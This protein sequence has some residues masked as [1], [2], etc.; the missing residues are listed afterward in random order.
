MLGFLTY[1]LN[2]S[3]KQFFENLWC[4]VQTASSIEFMHGC[5]LNNQP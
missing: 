1:F 4:D 5:H 2:E 3:M